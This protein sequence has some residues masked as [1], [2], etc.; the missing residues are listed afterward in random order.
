MTSTLLPKSVFDT[1]TLV[2]LLR[3]RAQHQSEKRAYVF[4]LDG[5]SEASEW[6]YGQLDQKARK[7]AAWLQANTNQGDRA[8]LLHPPGL[9]YIAAFF[10]CLYAGVVAV[11]IYPPRL[12]SR[13]MPRLRA[14]VAD[15]QATVALVTGNILDSLEQRFAAMPDLAALRWLAVDKLLPQG[16]SEWQYPAVSGDDIA[17]LQYTSGSTAAPRGVIITHNNVLHNLSLICQAFECTSDEEAVI[18]LPPYHDM[19]LIGGILT[20]LYYGYPVTLISP[21]AFL[22]KPFRWLQAISQNRATHSGGPNFAYELCVEQIT[23]EQ[24]A[25]LDLRSWTIAFNGAEPIRH[26]TI[27]RFSETFAPCGF[28]PEAFYPCYG[29]AEATLF[30]TGGVKNDPPRTHVVSKFSLEQ[31]R[32]VALDK[33][34][35]DAYELVGSGRLRSTPEVVIANPETGTEVPASEVGEIWLAGPSVAQGYWRNAAATRRVFQATLAGRDGR[36]FLRTGDLGFIHEQELFVVGRLKDIIIIRG[37]NHYPQDIEQTVAESHPAL[38]RD[39]GAAFSVTVNGEEKLVVVQEVTRQGRYVAAED[40]VKVVRRAVAERHGI[41]LYAL[42]LLKPFHLPKTS[43]G[44][45][46]R[47]VCRRAFLEGRLATVDE[48]TAVFQPDPPSAPEAKTAA[49]AATASPLPSSL[50]IQIWL[51]IRLARL[52]K[53][54]PREVD[55][56]Q[57]F[58]DY[59]LDSMVAVGLAGE[60]GEWLG[61]ELPGDLLLAYPT[62]ESLARYL[63]GEPTPAAP[64]ANSS[65]ERD[66]W[67]P[68]ASPPPANNPSRKQ[69]LPPPAPPPTEEAR[70]ASPY[71]NGRLPQ[72]GHSYAQYVNPPLAHLLSHFQMDRR[73]VRGEGCWL[74]DDDGE[75]YLHLMAAGG[76]LPFGF[77]APEIWN[78]VYEVAE[79]KTPALAHPSLLDDAGELARRLVE[80]A[81]PG[82]VRVVLVNNSTE[83]VETAVALARA[84]T[85]RMGILATDD[86]TPDQAPAA[87]SSVGYRYGQEPFSVPIPGLATLPYGDLVA[88]EDVL[89]QYASKIAAFIVE[90][91]QEGGDVVEPPPGYLAGARALC[92]Q[93]DVLLI[94]DERYTGLGRTGNLFICEAERIKPDMLLVGGALGGGLVSAGAV[95]AT[96]A[97]Y[98]ETFALRHSSTFAGNGLACRIGL[99]TLELLT[100]DREALIW[101][102]AENGAYL[103]TALRAL[104]RHFPQILTAV[105]GRGYMLSLQFTEQRAPFG[106]HTL[107]GPIAARKRLAM[108]VAGY[109]LNVEKIRV[110]PGGLDTQ[111]ILLEPP[112]ITG[113]AMGERFVTALH[114]L[115]EHLQAGNTA[116]LVTYMAGRDEPVAPLKAAPSPVNVTP[117]ANSQERKFAFLVHP[118]TARDFIDFDATLATF[119]EEELEK[120]SPRWQHM[121]DSFVVAGTHI[122]AETGETVYGEFIGLPF[123]AAA[124]LQM[125]TP[126][127]LAAL[128]RAVTLAKERGAAII[129]LGGYTSIVSRNGLALRDMDVPLTTG[130]SY[131][132][133]AADA[134]IREACKKVNLDL[135]GATVAILGASG[136]IGRMMAMLLAEKTGR[137]ILIGN[138]DHPQ[139]S[140]VRLQA[141]ARDIVRHLAGLAV[142]GKSFAPG[143]VGDI[144]LRSR[145]ATAVHTATETEDSDAPLLKHI[146]SHLVNAGRL[147]LTTE[148]DGSLL[149]ADVVLTATSSPEALLQP[150]HLGLGT[151]VCDVARPSNVSPRVPQERA[152]V[153]VL[154]CGIVGVPGRPELGWTFGLRPGMVYANMAETMILSM[155]HF[156]RHGTLGVDLNRRFLQILR[157]LAH[158]YGFRLA[159]ISS[160]GRSL[161]EADWQ[162]A[163][164]ARRQRRPD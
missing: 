141:V 37:R 151:I 89:S 39:A 30:V 113:R 124:L 78:A 32:V 35:A 122:T 73:F 148:K 90:P 96:E 91:I 70:S 126:Q 12:N 49:G 58:T 65:P 72:R 111:T 71:R 159:G 131:T 135:A 57:P 85:G 149:T 145:S 81:P 160:F 129:G 51:I 24:R 144:L 47:H 64:P 105:R 6:T 74:W 46:Q 63:A 98:S 161:A 119:S 153:L 59:G 84:I 92:T 10:G 79:E 93:Y 55:I 56:Q 116:Q 42:V 14:I 163:L 114:H 20:P 142:E 22:Q 123:T 34:D 53:V 107:L 138:P 134:V 80:L 4:L 62:I 106:H 155:A 120:L 88:L 136:S 29:L 67:A 99:R 104:Q 140:E 8:L 28:R 103:K 83:I 109:L 128:R 101:Q 100:R 125:P 156:N 118:F 60:L 95:L 94:V 77:N 5:E 3:L 150:H 9:D 130:N 26:A 16:E 158:K 50:N 18:W 25:T 36:Y 45:I 164:E 44:K 108:L 154:D 97:A 162:R 13:P 17:F 112:L 143:T 54:P 146:L 152:D 117:P 2:E 82:L 76:A 121:L 68:N 137:L 61:Q 52:L 110:S 19:G 11:P 102:V 133:V 15:A 41:N 127:A 33:Q 75:R 38:A 48:G 23:A 157:R 31:K 147:V 66:D 7:I 40:V 1:K 115:L 21:T 139:E 43:S 69:P 87:L 27:T 132:V 86:S